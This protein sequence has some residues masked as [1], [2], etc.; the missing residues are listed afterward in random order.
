[1]IHETLNH[2]LAEMEHPAWTLAE[3]KARVRQSLVTAFPPMFGDN[4]EKARRI[5]LDRFEATHLERLSPLPGAERLLGQLSGTHL[6][7]VSNKTGRLLRREVEALG[8]QHYFGRIV[9]AGDADCD[10]PHRAPID[11]ALTG[12]GIAAGEGVWYVGDT[13]IDVEC[14]VNAGCVPVLVHGA[15]H[16]LAHHRFADLAALDAALARGT[17]DLLPAGQPVG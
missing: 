9:G 11:L 6:A 3:T 16:P 10:K 4:W 8:W 17:A 13:E 1:I 2:T 12:S 5:Y 15:E 14:A 7:I